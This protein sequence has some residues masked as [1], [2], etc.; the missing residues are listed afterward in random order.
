MSLIHTAHDRRHVGLD[1]RSRTLGTALPAKDIRHEI[2]LRQL[3]SCRNPIHHNPD[4]LPMGLTENAYSE[5][6]ACRIHILQLYS[7][8]LTWSVP[9]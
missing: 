2:L 4:D 1:A 8:I 7:F 3:Q 6:S 5:S 9:Y